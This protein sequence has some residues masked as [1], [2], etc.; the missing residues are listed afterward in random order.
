MKPMLCALLLATASF[1]AIAP[2]QAPRG[3][4]SK[5]E[6]LELVTR[7]VPNRVIAEAVQQ[8]GIAFEPTEEVLN[9]FRK[10]GADDVVLRAMRDSWRPEPA[11]PLSDKDILLLLA[12]DVRSENIVNMV[13]RRGIG[14]Q[15]TA[16]YLQRLRS[17]GAKDELIEA[18]RVA[19]A[20]PFSRDRLLQWLARGGDTGQIG[21]EV[22]ERGI[23]F[24]PTEEELGKLRAA[25]ASESLLQAI[26]EAKRVKPPVNQLP[27]PP[28]SMSSRLTG[29][30]T[31]RGPMGARVIC[32]PSVSSIPVFASPNDMHTTVAELRC[33]DQVRILEKDSGRIGIDKILAA[34]GT[35]GF[36]QD[37]YL[38]GSTPP[39]YGTPP[40]PTYSPEPPYTPQARRDKIEGSVDLWIDIDSQGNVTD[41]QEASKPVGDGLDEKAIETVKTWKFKPATRNGVPVPVRVKVVITFRLYH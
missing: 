40:A 4:L 9:E 37:S 28:A 11:K 1:F 12:G 39:R 20:K 15:P 34:G 2:P 24:D 41:A 29:T 5:A 3:P 17:S 33:G 22:Q 16:E 25:G 10:A 36:V 8:Y 7:S 38:S 18:L 14:F 26:R 6:V 23:D 21:K 30:S 19:A 32:P 31:A 27:N 13:Q 35:K